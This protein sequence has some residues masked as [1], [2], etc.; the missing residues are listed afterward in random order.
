MVSG[1]GLLARLRGTGDFGPYSLDFSLCDAE[2]RRAF[3]AWLGCLDLAG[4]EVFDP[5]SLPASMLDLLRDLAPPL[6]LALAAADWVLPS[7]SPR[8][9]PCEQPSGADHCPSCATPFLREETAGS[10]SIGWRDWIAEARS[11][12]PLDK[13]SEI[14]AKH[15]FAGTEIGGAPAFDDRVWAEPSVRPALADG[16][17]AIIAPAPC[18]LADRL[19][20]GLGRA[21]LREG[22][23]TRIVV[24][25]ECVDDLT[26]MN[27][28]NVFVAGRV[29]TGKMSACFANMK[30][31]P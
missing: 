24:F 6:D 8:P 26:V 27:P 30:S 15:V 31:A 20:I 10:S 21:L 4:A 28:G 22:A 17:L 23:A 2:G 11:I 14:F 13:M 1:A 12:Q 5:L 16:A 25:G 19:T 7:P 29:E 3:R 18:A 9:G